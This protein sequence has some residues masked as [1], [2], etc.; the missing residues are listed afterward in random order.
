[1]NIVDFTEN[2]N[3]EDNLIL[4]L[5]NKKYLVFL[6]ILEMYK[7]KHIAKNCS[8]FYYDSKEDIN[9]KRK[10]TVA[11]HIY[12]SQKL[13]DFFI[14]NE[15]EFLKL[16]KLKIL[17]LLMYHDDIEILTQDTCISQEEKRK[18]KSIE[19][20]LLI[21]ILSNKYPNI[22]KDKLLILDKE[23]RENITMESKFA[24]AID[25]MD[26]LVHELQYPA[27]WKF[28]WFTEE[29]VIKWFQPSFEYSQTFMKYF[30]LILEF[31]RE[32]DYI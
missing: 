8:N 19:E 24:N 18:I 21:P 5:S 12:S 14:L 32:N 25:K 13:A 26:A 7:L 23:Y 30:Q 11:E 3:R 6:E 27:D 20:T 16:D 2:K 22:Q 28:K 15:K 1:M 4:N 29:N 9:Y 31:L 10:E 17:E